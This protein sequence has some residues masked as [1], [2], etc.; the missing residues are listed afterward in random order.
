MNNIPMT[1][2]DYLKVSYWRNALYH[3]WTNNN[4]LLLL[5]LKASNSFNIIVRRTWWSQSKMGIV[6]LPK[7]S[8]APSESLLNVVL[9]RREG[10]FP[11][12][13]HFYCLNY[14]FTELGIVIGWRNYVYVSQCN[15]PFGLD[16][17]S[18]F[19]WLLKGPSVEVPLSFRSSKIVNPPD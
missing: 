6:S 16:S 12:N 1:Q 7:S 15:Y 14:L 9:S 10:M 3:E 4:L 8:I 18:R 17:D 11:K 5:R 2:S 13:R 19:P